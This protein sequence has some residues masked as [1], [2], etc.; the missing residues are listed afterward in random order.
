MNVV[1]RMTGSRDIVFVDES[2]AKLFDLYYMV[3]LRADIGLLSLPFL[4]LAMPA[5]PANEIS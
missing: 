5:V 3:R 4:H 2:L 1:I